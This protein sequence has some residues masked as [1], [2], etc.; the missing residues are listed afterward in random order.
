M[1]KIVF[2]L[3]FLAVAP[4]HA[5]WGV[6]EIPYT[7]EARNL[8]YNDLTS[9]MACLCGCGTTLKTCPHEQCDFGIPAKKEIRQFIDMG[10]TKDEVIA[11]MIELRGETIL[12]A[13][14]FKGFNILA[15]VTPF[16]AII[17]VGYGIVVLLRQWAGRKKESDKTAKGEEL[18]ATDPY[19]K[20]LKDELG[21]FDD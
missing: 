16:F 7:P 15:W 9:N 4:M 17:F 21:R 1:K 3:I 8:L 19:M 11:K 14:Q 10:N 13:P 5:A 6:D 2:L 20:K 18:S 12:A